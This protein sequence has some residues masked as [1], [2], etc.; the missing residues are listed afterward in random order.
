MEKEK[1]VR[2][3]TTEEQAECRRHLAADF[4][5]HLAVKRGVKLRSASGG[6]WDHTDDEDVPGLLLAQTQE[7]SDIAEQNSFKEA[8]TVAETLWYDSLAE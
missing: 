6:C 3:H 1:R 2:E 5:V 7:L 4:L 8:A